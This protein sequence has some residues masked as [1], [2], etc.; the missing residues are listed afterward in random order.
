MKI[1]VICCASVGGSGIVAT[2]LAKC[3]ARRGHEIHVVSR[4]QPLDS[5]LGC[6]WLS[7]RD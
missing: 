4:E 1:A 5:H 6:F 7:S 3:L 2:E